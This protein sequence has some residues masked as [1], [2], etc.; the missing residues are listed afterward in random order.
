MTTTANAPRNVHQGRN[1]KRFREMKMMKQETLAYAL[2]DD[3]T[4]K[5]ISLLEAKEEIEPEL[6][7]QVAKVLDVPAEAIRNF[8]EEAAV[9]IISNTFHHTNGLIN[10]N[11]T[12]TVNPVEKWLEALEENKR[13]HQEKSELYER[14]LKDRDT[15]IEQLQ[16]IISEKL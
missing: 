16:K 1:V 14:M 13:L 15:L 4:Q 10:Y 5:K 12:Y 9:N 2:G 8:T 6:L 11:P 7:E 3:W